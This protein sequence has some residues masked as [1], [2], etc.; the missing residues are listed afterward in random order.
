[1]DMSILTR[2]SKHL[3]FGQ[4][5]QSSWTTIIKLLNG[6][7]SNGT[8]SEIEQNIFDIINQDDQ[9]S[10]VKWDILCLL[11]TYLLPPTCNLITYLPIYQLTPYLNII[12][13]F[14]NPP[15][16]LNVTHVPIYPPTY[17]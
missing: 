11:H 10:L 4:H 5:I 8:F 12:H 7:W 16:Y 3:F 17:D 6:F 9:C 2:G 13:L 15:T 1:M 14:T